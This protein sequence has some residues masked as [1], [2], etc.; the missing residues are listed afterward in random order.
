MYQKREKVQICKREDLGGPL[1]PLCVR[2]LASVPAGLTKVAAHRAL[3]GTSGAWEQ[4]VR[5]WSQELF[6]LH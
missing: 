1:G 3:R 4:R 5:L 2:R 6:P